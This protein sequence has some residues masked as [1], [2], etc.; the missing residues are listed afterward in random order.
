MTPWAQYTLWW[1]RLFLT[2]IKIST[3]HY[4]LGISQA[5]PAKD[6]VAEKETNEGNSEK[7]VPA[8]EKKDST[9]G[10]EASKPTAISELNILEE[11]LKSWFQNH[12][13]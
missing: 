1:K 3:Q 2:V 7:I 13:D 11:S 4:Q 5:S 8:L 12:A 9:E 6:K 10:T